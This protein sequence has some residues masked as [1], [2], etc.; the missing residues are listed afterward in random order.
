M[1]VEILSVANMP[2]LD[3]ASFE[4]EFTMHWLWK[5]RDKAQLLAE[6]APRVRGIQ[7]TGSSTV[8]AQ[9]IERLPKLEII[10]CCGVGYDGIDVAAA[11]KRNVVVTNTP[12]VLNDCVADLAIGLLIAASRGIGR[13]ERHVRA[14]KWLQGGVPLQTRVS[15][16]RLG[17]VGMGRIGRVI[18]ERAAGFDM[19]IAY[20]SRR[21]VADVPFAYY[22]KLV[23]LARDSDFLVAIVPGGKETLHLIDEAVLRALGPKGI[24]VNVARGSVVDEAALVRCLQD[25]ALGGA[26]LDVFEEEPKMPEALWSMENVVLTPHIGSGTH[27][28]RAAMSRLTLDNL[29]AHF[30]GRPV[31]TP[32]P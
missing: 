7:A 32:V 23:D 2:G 1:A 27:E 15:G 29:V 12:D 6:V 10:A 21:K 8:D 19:T 9:L 18:A 16:K 24:L 13:G 17:I 3:L 4:R 26:G 31:L 11:R 5:A 22:D 30:A 14:G 25:G 28:T 20:H